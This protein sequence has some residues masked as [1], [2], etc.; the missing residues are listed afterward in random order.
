MFRGLANR[1]NA[2]FSSSD[3]VID[4]GNTST[5]TDMGFSLEE[6]RN[7]LRSTNGDITQAA[8]LLLL[9]GAA[10]DTTATTTS[11]VPSS[12]QAAP[13]RQPTYNNNDD[14]DLQRA[15]KESLDIH[16]QNNNTNK[17]LVPKKK[18]TKQLP[19]QLKDKSQ[20]EQISRCVSRLQP[21]PLAIDTILIALTAIRDH[22]E[23]Q[24]FRSIDTF[25]PGY[26]DTLL[27]VPGAQDLLLCIRFQ[28]QGQFLKLDRFQI[29]LALLW[30]AIS[31]LQNATSSQEYIAGKQLLHFHRNL[32]QMLQQQTSES[33]NYK[34][35]SEPGST[36]NASLIHLQL[37]DSITHKRRFHPDDTLQDIM[38][39][40][41]TLASQIPNKIT[42]NE[43]VL[44][45]RGFSPPKSIPMNSHMLRK[46]LQTLGLWPSAKLQILIKDM[47]L[48]DGTSH[49]GNERGL[50][51]AL[52]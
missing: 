6:S 13:H 43:W 3:E 39:W 23:N 4:L 24:K 17:E 46:T 34:L 45:D 21:F 19:P 22:P 9:S 33:S 15:L 16:K 50:G 27:N 29:D 37:T 1:L 51:V 31:S 10:S 12:R 47:L 44:V 26:Q 20:E 7:A 52:P 30:L 32:Q 2:A 28:K 11:T 14:T 36:Q 8:N 35:S 5:L 49:F 41:G 38:S 42:T 25:T 40:I 48:D 18:K